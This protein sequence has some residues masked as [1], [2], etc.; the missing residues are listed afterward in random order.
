[1]PRLTGA[2][3][4]VST[5]YG[6]STFE[7]DRPI[8]GYTKVGIGGIWNTGEI[9]GRGF[10]KRKTLATASVGQTP[11]RNELFE[12]AGSWP[13][14]PLPVDCRKPVFVVLGIPRIGPPSDR[15]GLVPLLGCLIS[16]YNTFLPGMNSCTCATASVW[17]IPG[18]FELFETATNPICRSKLQISEP[19]Y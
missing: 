4:A 18:C 10:C 17:P 16:K 13:F 11:G 15:Y 8:G 12:T 9:G 19:S 14:W 2:V 7:W 6:E 5:P 1:M 3:R